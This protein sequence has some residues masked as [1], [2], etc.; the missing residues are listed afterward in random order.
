[1]TGQA[2]FDPSVQ[3]AVH[4]RRYQLLQHA[5]LLCCIHKMKCRRKLVIQGNSVIE[6]R[7]S[8]KNYLKVLAKFVDLAT[9]Y[10]KFDKKN[11]KIL[12]QTLY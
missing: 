11:I 12:Q 5:K 7:A 2:G 1:V 10:N 8:T 9:L 6:A 3:D 4:I